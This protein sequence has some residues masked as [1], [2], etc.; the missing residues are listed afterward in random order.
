MSGNFYSL[1]PEALAVG[2]S[3]CAF[4]VL[5]WF[6]GQEKLVDLGDEPDR[7]DAASLQIFE[8]MPSAQG[9]CESAAGISVYAAG[10]PAIQV[11]ASFVGP[12]PLP[13]RGL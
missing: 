1:Q 9:G 3:M 13:R 4:L 11:R 8:A 12:P 2:E 5:R 10:D 6:T 7:R